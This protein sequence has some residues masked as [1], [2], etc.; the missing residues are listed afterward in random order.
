MQK[1]GKSILA[2]NNPFLLLLACYW[3]QKLQPVQ[4][5]TWQAVT[6]SHW[7]ARNST[8][9]SRRTHRNRNLQ[10]FCF[11]IISFIKHLQNRKTNPKMSIMILSSPAKNTILQKIHFNFSFT[12]RKNWTD[13]IAQTPTQLP[14]WFKRNDVNGTS[15]FRPDNERGLHDHRGKFAAGGIPKGWREI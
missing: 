1:I 9:T 11:S 10:I 14:N 5:Q 6:T 7:D 15:D 3:V 8:Q 13:N 12:R 2:Y 4:L